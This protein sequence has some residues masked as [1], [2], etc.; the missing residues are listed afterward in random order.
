MSHP[1]PHLAQPLL[2]LL[3]LL[4]MM[5][6]NT[7][8]LPPSHPGPLLLLLLLRWGG[9]RVR[10]EPIIVQGR[11]VE[12]GVHGL[13]WCGCLWLLLLLLLL[14]MFRLEGGEGFLA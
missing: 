2:A 11:V 3:V 13:V 6:K 1:L 5:S 14:V 4:R 12:G 10:H 8:P 9:S 7:T